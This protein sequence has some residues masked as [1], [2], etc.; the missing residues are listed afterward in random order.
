MEWSI[1]RIAKLAGVSSRTLRHYDAVGILAPARTDASG[2]RWYDEASLA[3]L[4]RILLL[5]GLGVGIPAIAE[6]LQRASDEEAL[7]SHLADLGREADRIRRQIRA[8]EQTLRAREGGAAM[9]AEGA[10]D[11]FDQSQYE[12][13]VTERWGRKAWE[14]S[15]SWWKGMSEDDKRRFGQE[16][17][18]IAAGYAAARAAGT[19]VDADEVQALV[20]RHYAWVGAGWQTA[21][22]PLEAFA[23]LGDM[24]VADER[25]AANYGG[26]EGAAY[27]RDAMRRFVERRKA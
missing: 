17:L 27:V 7:R 15:Q 14:D 16:H 24:Y 26:T 8:V 10:L 2:M 20:E 19:P 3:R 22:P 4:Q 18:D 25:F 11:G 5:R 23:G 6:S 12:Q 1:Q 21:S 13:E 9:T